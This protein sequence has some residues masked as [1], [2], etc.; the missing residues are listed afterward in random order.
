MTQGSQQ[1]T[2]SNDVY[3]TTAAQAK[4]YIGKTLYWDSVDRS[5]RGYVF[6]RS[7]TL[8]EVSRGRLLFD[9]G[10]HESIGSFPSLRTFA[11]GGAYGRAIKE[12]DAINAAVKAAAEKKG[13]AI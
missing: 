12:K 2:A 10:N 9:G 8:E 3:I 11:N 5:G 1:E 7:G 13:E 6:L 4:G